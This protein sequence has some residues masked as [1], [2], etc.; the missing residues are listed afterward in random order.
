[1]A[2]GVSNVRAGHIGKPK[3][4]TDDGEIDGTLSCERS[5]ASCERSH[6]STDVACGHE[7]MGEAIG[8]VYMPILGSCL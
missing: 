5:H 7:S 4:T 2:G 8:G 1:M 6:V 3:E